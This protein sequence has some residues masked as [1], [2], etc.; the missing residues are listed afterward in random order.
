MNQLP[1]RRVTLTITLI[2]NSDER[3][4]A[5]IEEMVMTDGAALAYE[6]VDMTEVRARESENPADR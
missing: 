6:I 1:Q 5:I 4:K 2:A 3:A